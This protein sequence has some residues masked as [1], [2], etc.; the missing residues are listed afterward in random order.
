MTAPPCDG[1]A[2]ARA[3]GAAVW[4]GTL[5]GELGRP[6]AHDAGYAIRE[7]NTTPRAV[8]Q[9]VL[10]DDI[11]CLHGGGGKRVHRWHGPSHTVHDVDCG[12][13]T[14]MPR[15]QHNRWLTF[16][17]IDYVHLT[18]GADL[19]GAIAREEFGCDRRDVEFGDDVGFRDPLAEMLFGELRRGAHRP[20]GERLYTDGVAAA[21]VGRLLL[22]RSTLSERRRSAHLGATRSTVKGGLPGWRLRKV[23]EFLREHLA[24]DVALGD[25]SSMAG[26][27]R[28]QFFRA[29]RQS[30][31]T[32]PARYLADLRV[33]RAREL[34]SN[35]V[36]IDDIV[37][38]TGFSSPCHLNSAF[39]RRFGQT[40]KQFVGGRVRLRR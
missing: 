29:F 15:G 8:E 34:V 2:T 1:T 30:T 28:A 22:T 25:L 31:G 7:F 24:D 14:L 6:A 3:V 35:G 39:S 10:A 12:A 26:V 5:A 21:L 38:A 17:P 9:P 40:P 18:P 4:H 27:G 19:V 36:G 23:A 13:L 11:I 32:T 37:R 33:E 20:T 16:G